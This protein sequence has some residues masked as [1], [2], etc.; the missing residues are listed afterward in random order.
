[1]AVMSP[2][3]KIICYHEELR[4][5]L[6]AALKVADKKLFGSIQFRPL[7]EDGVLQISALNKTSTFVATVPTEMCDVVDQRDEVFECL[8]SEASVMAKFPIKLPPGSEGEV[9]KAGLI[10]ADSWI[11]ITDETGLGIG[12]RHSRVRRNSDL[13]LPG[14]ADRT[15]E[16]AIDADE[17]FDA[18]LFPAQT[19]LVGRVAE[20]MGQKHQIRLLKAPEGVLSRVLLSGATYGLTCTE[21]RQKDEDTDTSD[22]QPLSFDDSGLSVTSSKSLKI[23]GASPAHGVS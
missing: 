14:H 2:Q 11:Q 17:D 15:I 13:E 10:I 5:A 8:L 16:T 3:S 9:A 20:I 12:I 23:V 6:L 21:G 4:S 1:M 7:P 19:A 18:V 22:D